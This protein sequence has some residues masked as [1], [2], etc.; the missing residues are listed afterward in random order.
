MLPMVRQKCLDLISNLSTVPDVATKVIKY[1][2]WFLDHLLIMVRDGDLVSDK[3]PALSVLIR[4]LKVMLIDRIIVSYTKLI[5][6]QY[7][8]CIVDILEDPKY[9]DQNFVPFFIKFEFISMQSLTV[10]LGDHEYSQ[11]WSDKAK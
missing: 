10:I 7:I 4:M 1:Q 3:I 5:D 6:L 8:D 11:F 9:A 2:S